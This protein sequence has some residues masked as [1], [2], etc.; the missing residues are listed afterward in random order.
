LIKK[1]F[2]LH[3]TKFSGEKNVKAQKVMVDNN[4]G[5]LRSRAKII[6][7]TTMWGMKMLSIVR[8]FDM[9]YGKLKDLWGESGGISVEEARA[10]REDALNA[11]REFSKFMERFSE[12]VDFTYYPPKGL[13]NRK[14]DI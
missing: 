9:A 4:T 5:N 1:Y 6:Q 3:Q 11:M 13:K 7:L 10:I 2:F 12:G 14:A 8:Q